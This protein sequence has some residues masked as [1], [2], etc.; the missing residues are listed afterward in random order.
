MLRKIIGPILLVVAASVAQ[1]QDLPMV[2]KVMNFSSQPWRLRTL[3][4]Q[5]TEATPYPEVRELP[6]YTVQ[7]GSSLSMDFTHLDWYG[8]RVLRMIDWAGGSACVLV[9]TRSQEAG[10]SLMLEA[11][12]GED[13]RVPQTAYA[14]DGQTIAIMEDA[15]HSDAKSKKPPRRPPGGP[16]GRGELAPRVL[17]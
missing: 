5:P 13:E 11:D 9:L 1:A 4:P 6:T 16:K 2:A 15:F 7:P 3:P 8:T 17:F 12:F 10:V 14:R